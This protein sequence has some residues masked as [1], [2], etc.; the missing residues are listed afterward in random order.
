MTIYPERSFLRA[1]RK[2]KVLDQ[3]E[4]D[5]A[6]GRLPG[7]IGQPHAHR[8]ASVRRLKPG[9]FELRAGL[10]LRVV[11]TISKDV[12]ILWTVGDHD[13]VQAWLRNVK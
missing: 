2:L 10:R 7:I 12:A 6:V 5:A 8:G 9:I 1:F 3:K 11:F 13:D 4:V